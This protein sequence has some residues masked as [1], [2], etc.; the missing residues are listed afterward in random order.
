MKSWIDSCGLIK[1]AESLR[2][3]TFYAGYGILH[4]QKL[5]LIDDS[6]VFLITINAKIISRRSTS[7]D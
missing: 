3:M 1:E 4:G 5:D 6:R 2:L 7:Y